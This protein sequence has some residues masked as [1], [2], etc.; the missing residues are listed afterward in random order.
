[1][2][3]FAFISA[4][5]CYNNEID[6]PDNPQ[7]P[8]QSGLSITA[9]MAKTRVNYGNETD[10]Q[11]LPVWEP[12]D[13]LFGFYVDGDGDG[14][15]DIQNFI[16]KVTRISA[17][18][19]G[20]SYATLG[21]VEG[22]ENGL[23][24][25]PVNTPVYLIYTGKN[26]ANS[27]TD[28]DKFTS[29]GFPVDLTSQNL[30]H[31]PVC[32]SATATIGGNDAAK[33]LSFNFAYDCAVLEVETLA[34][35]GKEGFAPGSLSGIEVSGISFMG[36]YSYDNGNITF[37]AV[38]DDTSYSQSLDG[39]SVSA[40][41]ELTCSGE[42][43]KILISA[44]P[45]SS[46]N[47]KISYKRNDSNICS[48]TFSNRTLAKGNCY[49]IRHNYVAKTSDNHY[50]ETVAEAFD[51][52]SKY[53]AYNTVTLVRKHIDG[54]G[55]HPEPDEDGDG[56]ASLMVE[57]DY[58]VTLDLNG[59][60]L[61]LSDAKVNGANDTSEY[62][63]VDAYS[64]EYDT[65]DGHFTIVDSKSGG[66][67]ESVSNAHVIKNEGTVTISGGFIT[68][69]EQWI[70][71][72]TWCAVRNYGPGML[73]VENGAKLNS[74]FYDTV[75]NEGTVIVKGGKIYSDNYNA[76]NNTYDEDYEGVVKIFGGELYS[77][78]GIA[79]QSDAGSVVIG[80]SE[81]TP[82]DRT[83]I[84][85]YTNS[86]YFAISC[87]D[88]SFDVH[89]GNVRAGEGAAVELNGGVQSSIDGGYFKSS[90]VFGTL[91]I[92]EGP[93][94]E[95][96]GGTIYNKGVNG[97]CPAIF[98]YDDKNKGTSLEVKW[99]KGTTYNDNA[100]YIIT[101]EGK[102]EPLI[103]SSG[104]DKFCS[105]IRKTHT[106]D[107]K[108]FSTLKISGGY[109][110]SNNSAFYAQDVY[111]S[112]SFDPMSNNVFDGFYANTPILNNSANSS[113]GYSVSLNESGHEYPQYNASS[114][115]NGFTID[116]IS[117]SL[118]TGDLYIITQSGSQGAVAKYQFNNFVW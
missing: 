27:I 9:T 28:A 93:K 7:N 76:I 83:D 1:M 116:T 71:G 84:N 72:G 88:G 110:I 51:Y 31:I 21:F 33:T 50:F 68:Q 56:D 104:T 66:T 97:S 118:S 90:S 13:I 99:P 4:A 47:I 62:F 20:S 100:G 80:N 26:G 85:I 43:K 37:A 46:D 115:G 29:D 42:T 59:C 49:V 75:L 114:A 14:D 109:L 74:V 95:I 77:N 103:F 89:Y 86:N 15:G 78:A 54:L 79:I 22:N 113:S 81:L 30:D 3:A 45:T 98:L 117:S 11:L 10:E 70:D 32:M 16:L 94:C 6:N 19:S 23:A 102:H 40:D 107:S 63:Y 105:P 2:S 17:N 36:K 18:D 61:F 108:D 87:S 64:D 25:Q 73:E 82:N 34:G 106:N 55:E 35:F 48:E 38:A 111:T 69:T 24:N 52:V 44:I 112:G 5:A 12:D 41:S 60:M 101:G 67:I 65:G 8:E 53:P 91:Y 57:I 96:S 92:H 58:D 39:W